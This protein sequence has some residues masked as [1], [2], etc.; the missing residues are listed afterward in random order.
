MRIDGTAKSVEEQCAEHPSDNVYDINGDLVAKCP[1]LRS[2]P[3]RLGGRVPRGGELIPGKK[4]EGER[5]SFEVLSLLSFYPR[6]DPSLPR[7]LIAV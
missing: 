5:R 6:V 2:D 7:I 1:H 3:P 4:K